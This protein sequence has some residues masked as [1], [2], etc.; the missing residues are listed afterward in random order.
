MRIDSHQHFWKYDVVLNSWIMDDMQI[1]RR[2]FLPEDLL[3][4]LI[5]NAIDGCVAIQADQSEKETDFLLTLA[6]ENYFVKGIVGWVDLCAENV[7]ERLQFYAN[8]PNFKG[9]RYILQ[10]QV[11]EFMLQKSFQYGISQLRHYNLTY[12]ILIYPHQLAESIKLVNQF[13]EQAFVLDHLAK[14]Y[15]R[16]GK[17]AD[18]KKDMEALAKHQNVCCK[19]SGMVTEADWKNWKASDIRPYMDVVL[20]VFGANRIMYGS[21]W[22]VCLLAGDYGQVLDLVQSYV[23]EL[24]QPEQE[25]VMGN[26]AKA[27]Y[28]L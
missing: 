12:D 23:N 10:G 25:A 22:P 27:F 2:D 24:S 28:M 9:V 15:I 13:P 18:W 20:D 26:T 3:T 17:I 21:D 4:P 14:P 1:I 6:D 5:G 11:P 16:K 8:N 7:G 19:L